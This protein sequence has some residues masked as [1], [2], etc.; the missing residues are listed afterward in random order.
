M[1][2][3]AKVTENECIKM[4]GTCTITN[5]FSSVLIDNRSSQRTATYILFLPK[6][7]HPAARS[8]CDSR[9]F[10]VMSQTENG[11]RN[12]IYFQNEE[13]GN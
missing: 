4:T 8:L 11:N 9:A 12:D 7:T 6:L 13:H 2:I 10:R 5:T 1:A 3:F